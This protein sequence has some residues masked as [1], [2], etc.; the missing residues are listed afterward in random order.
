MKKAT[1]HM[2]SQLFRTC[3]NLK[4]GYKREKNRSK[5][6]EPGNKQERLLPPLN[7]EIGLIIHLIS[8]HSFSTGKFSNFRIDY[9]YKIIIGHSD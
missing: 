3:R 9:F 1:H 6:S 5:V 4:A 7:A 8:Q 2:K